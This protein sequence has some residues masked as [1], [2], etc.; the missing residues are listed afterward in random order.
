[1]QQGKNQVIGDPTRRL[2]SFNQAGKTRAILTAEQAIKIFQIKLSNLNATKSQRI[3]PSSVAR[4]FGVSEKAIR[5]IWKG[6]T[7]LRETIHLDRA[8][9]ITEAN[10]QQQMQ[11]CL[12]LSL[13]QTGASH[14][15]KIVILHCDP[16]CV[17]INGA[18]IDSSAAN[19]PE[20]FVGWWDK[21]KPANPMD[22]N[23]VRSPV[24]ASWPTDTISEDSSGQHLAAAEVAPLPESSRA[25]DPF[26][27]DWQYWPRQEKGEEAR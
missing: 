17:A 7:W 12:N 24:S 6:R 1:M 13:A 4:A 8:Q 3:S 21:V 26:H 5:D 9:V 27:D 20:K 2:L 15:E 10:Q 23:D 14:I 22:A 18:C 16:S 19:R 25:D 11:S